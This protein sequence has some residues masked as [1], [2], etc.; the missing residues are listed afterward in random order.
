M[1][2]KPTLI[3]DLV[4]TREQRRGNFEAKR[5][6]GLEVNHQLKLGRR[7]HG[8]VGGLGVRPSRGSV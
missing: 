3:D 8:Q 7:L 2:Q 5:L 1:Q 6:S 4:G